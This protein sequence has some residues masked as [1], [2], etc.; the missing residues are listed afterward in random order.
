MRRLVVVA[1]LVALAIPFSAA[2]PAA[3][4]YEY[5]AESPGCGYLRFYPPRTG[6]SG[7]LPD[8]HTVRGPAGALFGRTIGAVKDQLV[9]WTVPMSDDARIQVHRRVLPALRQVEQNL[10]VEAEAGRTYPVWS[11]YTS[12]YSA[13][14]STAH[15]GIS[16]HALGAA[17]DINSIWNPYREDGKLITNIPPWF[18]QAWEDAGMCWG[19]S[20]NHVKDAMHFSWAGPKA[21]PAYGGLPAPV[22]PLTAA[23]PFDVPVGEHQVVFGPAD[24]PRFVSEASGD[25]APDVI[26]IR[27]W[28]ED[29]VLEAALSR[30]GFAACGVWRWW[31]EDPPAGTPQLVDV[32]G[33][34]RPD[35]VYL[36]ASGMNVVMARFAADAGY[37]RSPDIVTGVTTAENRRIAFGDIDGDGSDDLVTLGQVAGGLAIEVWSGASSYKTMVD[38][39]LVEGVDLGDHA[40]V[41]LADRTVDGRDDLLVVTPAVGSST[42]TVVSATNLS[43]VSEVTTG[44]HLSPSD[45][46]GVEDYDGDGRPDLLALSADANLRAWLG[47]SSL[48]GSASAWFV[49]GDF[50]CPEDTIP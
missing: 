26:Q 47:N 36:D 20:W 44:P 18:A 4:D 43:A 42:V 9:W 13:R 39:G 40:R 12:A 28:G 22:P 31:L 16:Y 32:A 27:P 50:E 6:R 30:G 19:G 8:S 15:D 24:Y 23:R 48:G 35:L 41:A 1:A 11:A 45:V 17:I 10:A 34:G 37:E 5:T 49:A 29:A 25:G 2:M 21:T 38:Q 33:S 46:V 7:W 14:T 3:A